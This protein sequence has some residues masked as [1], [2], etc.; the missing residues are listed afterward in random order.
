MRPL[1]AAS[2]HPRLST[3]SDAA[4]PF[5]GD[6]ADFTPTG[7]NIF[8]QKSFVDD[9]E[10]ALRL[11]WDFDQLGVPPLLPYGS[12]AVGS[13]LGDRAGGAVGSV[14]TPK[15]P[16]RADPVPPPSA[17]VTRRD[18]A[19]D[20]DEQP[21]PTSFTDRV[22]T[23]VFHSAANASA[24]L[25]QQTGT[26]AARRRFFASLVHLDLDLPLGAIYRTSSTASTR[27]CSLWPIV[28][29]YDFAARSHIRVSSFHRAPQWCGNEGNTPRE[30]TVAAA[31]LLAL[32]VLHTV[33]T[34]RA[35]VRRLLLLH[36]TRNDQHHMSRR[37]RRQQRFVLEA[38]GEVG[39]EEAAARRTAS[40]AGVLH[41][42]LP[43]ELA[44]AVAEAEADA[45]AHAK[46]L[47][48]RDRERGRDGEGK[49]EL[50]HKVSRPPTVPE[51]R[52]SAASSASSLSSASSASTITA[53]GDA[54]KASGLK[55][56][57]LTWAERR[58]VFSTWA[59]IAV[60]GD[61]CC[62]A[63]AAYAVLG[64]ASASDSVGPRVLLGLGC[65]LQWGAGLEYLEFASTMF[66]L[67]AT[68]RQSVPGILKVGC[69]DLPASAPARA[70]PLTLPRP[71]SSSWRRLRSSSP[72]PW[73][74]LPPSAA[75]CPASARSPPPA[76]PSSPSSTATSCA[77]RT[78]P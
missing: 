53:G 77:R 38:A 74:A 63:F 21:G 49:P 40:T 32:S 5:A 48:D 20:V 27:R 76:P 28:L 37:V 2:P 70:P 39:P 18:P 29:R 75:P 50:E 44:V 65:A 12:A 43:A 56:A 51:R 59:V 60:A 46:Q 71:R 26:V 14:Q 17:I 73:S 41:H 52:E 42:H 1:Q 58:G 8:T 62:A 25:Q 36:L 67:I 4:C 19:V 3:E 47:R 13:F 30:H 16:D 72:S 33:L 9:V 61:V 68:L 31:A 54:L 57:S 11:Y 64:G 66:T 55:W 7:Y 15:W 78:C 34:S 35:A 23:T 6:I 10:R 24:W 69:T 45:K 22:E